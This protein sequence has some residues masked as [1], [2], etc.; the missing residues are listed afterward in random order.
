MSGPIQTNPVGLLG[1]FQLKNMGKNPSEFMESL[2]PA[3]EMRD[4]YLQ[5]NSEI[6]SGV[7]AAIAAAGTA[8]YL[9]VPAGK[10]WAVHDVAISAN[11]AAAATIRLQPTYAMGPTGSALSFHFPLNEKVNW[12]QAT[13]GTTLVIRAD[14]AGRLLLIPPGG[15]LGIRTFALSAATTAGNVVARITEFVL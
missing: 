3:L 15:C 14:L 4:W 1:F 12:D 13:D 6:R 10:M 11:L 2:Q 8:R 7:D 9:E 5:T